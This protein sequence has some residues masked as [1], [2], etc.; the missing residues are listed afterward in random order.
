MPDSPEFEQW[1]LLQRERLRRQCDTSLRELV[2]YYGDRSEYEQALRFAWRRVDLD[3]L[4]GGA[5]PADTNARRRRRHR[6]SAPAVRCAAGSVAGRTR[7]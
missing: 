4:R 7:R 1:S 2:S 6:Q 3:P 5:L